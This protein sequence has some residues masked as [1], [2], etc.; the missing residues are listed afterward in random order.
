[1]KLVINRL[2]PI[3]KANLDLGDITVLIGPPNMG[4]SYTLK[5]LY[6]TLLMLD[7]SARKLALTRTFNELGFLKRRRYVDDEEIFH[8]LIYLAI[9]YKVYPQRVESIAKHIR[10]VFNISQINIKTENGSII[11]ASQRKENIDLKKL[12]NLIQEKVNLLWTILPTTDKTKVYLDVPMP[13][14]LPI[15]MESLKKPFNFRREDRDRHLRLH[16]TYGISST[17][18]EERRELILQITTEIRVEEKSPLIKEGTKRLSE[19]ILFKLEK[20]KNKREILEILKVLYT[21]NLRR[22]MFWIISEE[23]E[24]VIESIIN[25][26]VENIGKTLGVIYKNAIG[27][28]SVLFIPFGRS[29]LVYQLE[30]ISREPFV[31]MESLKDYYEFDM[32]LYSYMSKLS[33]G[34]A[35]LSGGNYEKEIVQ[36]FEPVLQGNLDFDKRSGELRYTRWGFG[37]AIDVPIKWASALAEEIVGILLPILAIPD[38]S[39]IIIEE[40]ESQLHYSAQVLMALALIGLS[41]HFNHKIAL[42]THSDIFALT[43]VYVQEFKPSKDKVLELIKKLFE[44]QNICVDDTNFEPLAKAVSENTD[45][46]IRFYYYEPTPKEVKV[47]ERKSS[48]ILKD[49]PSITDVANILATWAMSL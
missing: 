27:T 31:G 6:S 36:L 30:Y 18:Q 19:E 23:V 5:A 47:S 22:F 15:L 35:K 1:M 43:L 48:E 37:E 40:P 2:G 11:V 4:K 24:E 14:F 45:I 7:S 29:P 10:N 12:D 8:I 3:N 41:K 38:E 26:L 33:S 21:L 44:M 28:Q 25:Y 34:R 17:L 9:V 42:S 20:A 16:M 49:V 32:P 39:Y 46:D 13:S